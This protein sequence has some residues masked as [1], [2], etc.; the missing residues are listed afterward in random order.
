[1]PIP[2]AVNPA[3][4]TPGLYLS[5]NLLSGAASPGGGTLR[6]LLLAPK[7][8]TGTLTVQSEIRSGGGPDTAATA[9]G[10]GTPGHLAAKQIY[11]KNPS[12]QIDFG[13]PTAG[14]TNATLNVTASGTPTGNN[15]VHWDIMGREFDVEWNAGETADTFKTRAI[16]AINSRTTDLA[17]TASSGGVGIITLTGKVTGRISN[18]VR[19]KATLNLAATGT[20]AMAGALTHTPLAG[21]TTDPDFTTILAAASGKEY[22]YI[23]CC[24]SNTDA[25]TTGGASN[26]A[27]LI[28]HITTYQSGLNAKLQ[29][30]I[31][32][33]TSATMT[34]AK[35][36]AINRNKAEL[37]YVYTFAGRSLPCEF[38]ARELGG[39]LASVS[40][41]PAANR[42]GELFDNVYGSQDVIA[43][44]PTQA[45]L[46]DALTNGLS[47]LAFTPQG[48][49]YVVRPI[50]TYSQDSTG[51]AD[52][53]LLD[54]QN[55]DATYAVARDLRSALPAEFPNAK[56]S[57]D[58]I[59]G[60]EPPPKGVIE[61]KDVKAFVISRLRF[62]DREGV[63]LRAKLDAA[64]A[65]GT[66]IVA[67]NSTD[68]SQVDIVIPLTIVPPLAKF[69]VVVQ[70]RPN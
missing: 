39:R 30:G 63:I 60:E 65:D 46:E 45:E 13:A 51:G 43:D 1:M 61:E 69:G 7:D 22:A 56:I 57:K 36:A 14:A 40:L 66:L 2:L 47:I 52:R 33:S 26:V 48:Q 25:E 23:L 11:T 6:V 38:A 4:V 49:L 10:Q 15:S 8:G 64:I 54:T 29:Q 12:A 67:V 37:E 27:R 70:R 5:I 53:R 44:N 21:G 62:W 41:D 18:D 16:A 9:F 24:T 55:V 28:T 20:E 3:T 17:V 42:I 59:P 68:A 50:T 35:A 58:T 34:A 32:A 19:V 31:V